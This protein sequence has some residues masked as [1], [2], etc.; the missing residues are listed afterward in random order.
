MD[1]PEL[2]KEMDQAAGNIRQFKDIVQYK[3]ILTSIALLLLSLILSA[4]ETSRKECAYSRTVTTQQPYCSKEAPQTC[5]NYCD[6]YGC[7]QNCSGGGYCVETSYRTVTSEQCQSYRCQAGYI[8]VGDSCL[9]QAEIDERKVRS[10]QRAINAALKADDSGYLLSAIAYDYQTG[11]DGRPL[12]M[13]KAIKLYEQACT[14][15]SGY[16]CNALGLFFH[17][18]KVVEQ[19]LLRSIQLK[20]RAC[21]LGSQYGCYNLGMHYDAS[22]VIS[23]HVQATAAFEQ[24][25]EGGHTYGCAY[26][27][28]N[29]FNGKGIA[30]DKDLSKATINS[31]YSSAKDALND[32][33]EDSALKR[34]VDFLYGTRAN[35]YLAE[36][37]NPYTAFAEG[38]Y[39]E[40]L[41]VSDQRIDGAQALLNAG[42]ISS[43]EV[44]VELGMKSWR[45]LFAQDF[46][47]AQ[48][49]SERGVS[50][51]PDKIWIHSN[52][53]HALMFQGQDDAA[54]AIYLQYKGTNIPEQYDRLWEVVINEDF[55]A[56][57]AAGL[58]HPQMAE[59]R[60]A[61]R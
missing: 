2:G 10:E 34:G 14:L 33:P 51:A 5:S 8:A 50:L 38:R 35:I 44:A 59:I 54:A 15:G 20:R 42:Y 47:A 52:R 9:T 55:D 22:S 17:D 57:S 4:C 60:E 39:D 53:A 48:A 37:P 31:A 12:D 32:A 56:L 1:Q 11:T 49:A 13:P 7:R 25:C 40:A 23:D 30:A 21:D 46:A 19:D 36:L 29:L 41:G 24:A 45:A 18:G 6:S 58:S 27:A 16:S 28:L 3:R 43:A 26:Y 61:L